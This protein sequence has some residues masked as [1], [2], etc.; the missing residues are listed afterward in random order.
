[1][2][3]NRHIENAVW[4]QTLGKLRAVPVNL[5]TAPRGGWVA[6]AVVRQNTFFICECSFTLIYLTLI[7]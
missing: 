7:L 4:S 6:P 1:M 2:L 5:T 3:L